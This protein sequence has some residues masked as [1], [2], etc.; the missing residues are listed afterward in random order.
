MLRKKAPGGRPKAHAGP[1]PKNQLTLAAEARCQD[2][3]REVH[4][5]ELEID[6]IREQTA[7]ERALQEELRKKLEIA[8]NQTAQ[9][10]EAV[11]AKLRMK[12]HKASRC[13]QA[14]RILDSE[15]QQMCVGFLNVH[16]ANLEEPP[17]CRLRSAGVGGEAERRREGDDSL[18][19]GGEED[20]WW[21]NNDV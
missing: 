17:D 7:L 2:L 1:P 14:S 9:Q 15:E 20:M 6:E 3:E 18:Q 21:I 19:D 5:L 8:K 11:D 13:E 12:R 16:R 4:D 10:I